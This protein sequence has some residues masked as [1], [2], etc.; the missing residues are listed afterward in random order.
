MTLPHVACATTTPLRPCEAH[1]RSVFARHVS[2][3]AISWYTE[4]Q[5]EA[6]LCLHHDQ[7]QKH[8]ALRRCHRGF[9][10]RVYEYK[11]R[12]VKGFTRRY[13]ITKLVYYEVFEDM[14]NAILR[15][16]QIKGGSRRKKVEL[17]DSMNPDWCELYE[18]LV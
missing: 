2:A 13:N 11:E 9:V 8:G 15:E 1:T 14:E 10:K 18:G 17:I 3:E 16:K 7:Q 12:L 4:D 5:V 6:I